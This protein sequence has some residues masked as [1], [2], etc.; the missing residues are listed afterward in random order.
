MLG[1]LCIF[2]VFKISLFKSYFKF[3]DFPLIFHT[4]AIFF[5]NLKSNSVSSVDPVNFFGTVSF[6]SEIISCDEV[7][8]KYVPDVLTPTTFI[9]T[10]TFAADKS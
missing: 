10:S 6:F 3:A 4:P 7:L 1:T 2:L 5:I 9:D 8:Y